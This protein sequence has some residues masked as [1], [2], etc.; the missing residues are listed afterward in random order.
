MRRGGGGSRTRSTLV[1]ETT[2]IIV[3]GIL[4][5]AVGI[6]FIC[7]LV[8]SLAIYAL[9]FFAAVSVGLWAYHGDAGPVGAILVGILAGAVTLIAGQY[10]F[11]F[12]RSI[13]LRVA[14]ALLFA[15]PAALAG[16]HATLGIAK[17]TMPSE[18]WQIAFS[19]VGAVAIGVTAW[20]R[21]A[22]PA[23]HPTQGIVRS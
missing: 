13:W 23:G 12:A 7:W 6:G 10:V 11:G 21:I 22:L 8:F 18:A 20:T 14:V 4:F 1:T 5:G 15:A 9:P 19:I 2:T 17:L 16:Y 3:I